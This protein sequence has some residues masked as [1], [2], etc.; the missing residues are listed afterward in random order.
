MADPIAPP[1][2]PGAY[3]INKFFNLLIF[4]IL[5]FAKEFKAHPPA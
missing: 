5:P 1:E 4:S 3:G 2:S